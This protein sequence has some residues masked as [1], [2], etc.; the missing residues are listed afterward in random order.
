M[1]ALQ[2]MVRRDAVHGGSALFLYRK[3]AC[4][5][6]ANSL[7]LPAPP[8]AATEQ[9]RN[10]WGGPSLDKG[11][12]VG[13]GAFCCICSGS[14]LAHAPQA[15]DHWLTEYRARLAAV[16]SSAL[17]CKAHEANGSEQAFGPYSPTC[18]RYHYH[19]VPAQ[20]VLF[21]HIMQPLFKIAFSINLFVAHTVQNCVSEHT[22]R[23]SREYLLSLPRNDFATNVDAGTCYAARLFES[24]GD[25]DC[26]CVQKVPL[27][28]CGSS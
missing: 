9:V 8:A 1:H 14:D 11:S 5:R 24:A 10:S 16:S 27:W 19:I 17:H 25:I 26:V 6:P 13:A 7:F 20:Q 4:V 12:G 23:T 3:T 15:M 2:V 18:A 22:T 21:A 28:M